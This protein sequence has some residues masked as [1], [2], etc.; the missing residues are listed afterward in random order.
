MA[1]PNAA[2]FDD[3]IGVALESRGIS[4]GGAQIWDDFSQQPDGVPVA[5][6]SGTTYLLNGTHSASVTVASG[7]LIAVTP[8]ASVATYVQTPMRRPGTRVGARLAFSPYTVS[9]GCA[10]LGFWA[11]PMDNL[12]GT[13]VR[14][15]PCHFVIAPTLWSFSVWNEGDGSDI[16]VGSG[17]WQ[18]PLVA[19]GATEYSVD[20]QIDRRNSCAYVLVTGPSGVVIMNRKFSHSMIGSVPGNYAFIEHYR[21]AVTNTLPL[22]YD[23]WADSAV[24]SGRV[25]AQL[26]ASIPARPATIQYR[27]A[28]SVLYTAPTGASADVDATN[29]ALAFT[30]AT[31][32]AIVTFSGFV[33][34]FGATDLYWTVRIL[35]STFGSEQVVNGGEKSITPSDGKRTVQ[36]LITGL[37][38]GSPVVIKWGHLATLANAAVLWADAGTSRGLTMKA[39]SA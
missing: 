5:T 32:K 11:D 18:T 14:S 21:T 19:D 20:I 22:F 37:T 29:L 10:T 4:K 25:S 24:F 34:F 39:E 1:I 9:G 23:W 13:P 26:L 17:F 35:S 6:K 31:D 16:E 8:Q 30:P 28:S 36:F 7:K 38:P 3:V 2:D 27:P 15:S 33:K 12:T